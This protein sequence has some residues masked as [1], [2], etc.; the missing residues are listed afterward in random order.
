[1]R[2]AEAIRQWRPWDKSTGPQTAEGKSRASRNADRGGHRGNLR[3]FVKM[4][5]RS[6]GEQR[7]ALMSFNANVKV[8]VRELPKEAR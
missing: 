8:S 6:F 5:D 1:M 7:K 3:N 4:L 2:Q